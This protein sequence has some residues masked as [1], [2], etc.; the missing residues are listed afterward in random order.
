MEKLIKIFHYISFIKYPLLLIALYFC[1]KPVLL[2]QIDFLENF[3]IGL[4]FLG[5]AIGLDSLKDYEKLNWL[6]RKVL[7]KPK[8]AKYYFIYL[9]L[10]I[11]GFI[12]LGLKNYLSQDDSKLVEKLL[13]SRW[14]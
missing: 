12:F 1:Y 5:L 6:D 14:Q 11:F 9:G 2:D 10:I 3:N 7:H 4:I 8:I 13:I